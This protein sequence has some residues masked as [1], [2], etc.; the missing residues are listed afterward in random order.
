MCGSFAGDKAKD[1]ML[2]LDHIGEAKAK[3]RAKAKAGKSRWMAY[4]SPED[5]VDLWK[6]TNDLC[7]ATIKDWMACYAAVYVT[8][9]T[10]QD[11]RLWLRTD[12]G[13]IV[14]LDGARVFDGHH[15]EAID[16]DAPLR[17]PRG[18]SCLMLK[19]ENLAYD[20]NLKARLADPDGL[21]LEGVTI[22]IEPGK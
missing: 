20:I 6:A 10:E 7:N 9:A 4:T 12:D 3:P 14:F 18:T 17:L 11:A 1:D 22:G 2:A 13:V 8:S 5:L 19:V 15:H 21:P 16:L